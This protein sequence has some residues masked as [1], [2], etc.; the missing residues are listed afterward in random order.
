ML[1]VT[2]EQMVQMFQ[3]IIEESLYNKSHLF[4]KKKPSY[5]SFE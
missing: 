1:I 4:H 5:E 2:R 3:V